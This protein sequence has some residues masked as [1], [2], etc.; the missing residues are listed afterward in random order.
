M[1]INDMLLILGYVKKASPLKK[2]L[3]DMFQLPERMI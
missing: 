2:S 3:K 1:L